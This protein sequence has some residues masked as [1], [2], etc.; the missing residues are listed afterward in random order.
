LQTYW[1]KY[2]FERK[3][4]GYHNIAAFYN[5]LAKIANTIEGDIVENIGIDSLDLYK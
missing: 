1:T 5:T 4:Q 3:F 2:D